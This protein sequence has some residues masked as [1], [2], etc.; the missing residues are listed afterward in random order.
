[1]Y[2][3]RRVYKTKPGKTREAALLLKE[4]ADI[5]TEAAKR[6]KLKFSTMEELFRGL[7][8]S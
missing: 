4:I 7:K 3:I 1:M 5:Y 6:K 2:S 8:K